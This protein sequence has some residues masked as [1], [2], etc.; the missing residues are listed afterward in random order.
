MSAP[1]PPA[2]TAPTRRFLAWLDQ[3]TGYSVVAKLLLDQNIPGGASWWYSI[4]A[5]LVFLLALEASTGI[6]LAAFYAPSVTTAWASTAF[7]QDTLTFGWF[8]RGLHSFGSSALIALAGLHLLQ[9]LVFGA[10]RAPREVNWIVGLGMLGFLLAFALSGYGLPWDEKGYW[11]KQVETSIIGTVPVVGAYLETLLVG[12]TNYGNY[13]LTHFF[14]LHTLA[15]PAL[16]L[17]LLAVHLFLVRRHGVTPRWGRAEVDLTR[18]SQTY[19][20]YQ[21]ARDAVACG[22]TFVALA[23]LVMSTHGADLEGPADPAGSYQA[24]PEWYSLALYQLRKY[25]EGPLE[26]VATLAIPGAVTLLLV[27]LPWL[28]RAAGRDPRQRI[29]VL[30]GALVGVGAL[31]LLSYLPLRRDAQDQSYQQARAEVRLRATRARELAKEGVLPEGG[32]AVFRNDPAHQAREL[33]REHCSTCH[34]FSGQPGPPDREGGPDFKG[35]NTRAWIEG[36][37]RNPDGPLYMGAAKLEKGMRPVEGTDE[38]LRALT[39][40]VYAETGATDVVRPLVERAAPLLSEKDCDSCH[41]FDGTSESSGPN[42]KGRGTLAWVT[43]VITFAG[44]KRLF[45]SRNKMPRFGGKLTEEEIAHLAR[46]VMEESARQ[47]Q[48]PLAE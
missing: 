6:L 41:D 37:L 24:R 46:F 12:G 32:P 2:P 11:A 1:P 28:D 23:L 15:L 40:L 29:V 3:R 45:G 39:E 44:H 38:E 4:G 35:Y 48:G 13:T 26:I 17:V 8:I 27:A 19:W 5:L 10:Y 7:I 34:S 16:L 42:L 31:G 36:F 18:S 14:A 9:V 22:G 21:A 20:P 43:D 25:F 47:N 33:W 30:A